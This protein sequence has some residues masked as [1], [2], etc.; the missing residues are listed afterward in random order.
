M[1]IQCVKEKLQIAISKAE[2]I[3]GKNLTL[4]ILSNILLEVK[5]DNLV[6]SSTNLDIGIEITVPGKVTETGKVVVPGNVLY[7]LVHTLTDPKIT[8][9]TKDQTLHISSDN[10]STTIKTVSDEDFPSIPNIPSRESFEMNTEGFLDGIRSVFYAAS[11]SNMKPELSSVYITSDEGNVI[12]VATDSFRLA[13]KKIK[14][15]K[16][17]NFQDILIPVKNVVEIIKTLDGVSGD[18]SIQISEG[19]L[20]LRTEEIYL[21]SRLVDGN[22][23]DY[24][25]IIPKEVSTNA[26]VLKQDFMNSLRTANIFSDKFNKIKFKVSP[27]E[28]QFVLQTKNTDLGENTT[29][30]DAAFSGEE[31]ELNFNHKYIVDSFQS[32]YSDSISL[33]FNGEGKPMIIKGVSD[34][35]FLY[36]AMPMSN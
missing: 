27:K 34:S 13:E 26:T 24:K 20:T 16:T 1:K 28:K 10:T 4:P 15:K 35:N 12:F 29:L 9:E 25:Q 30:I 6:I 7:S 19:Q 21:T 8:L 5:K 2:K 17:P 11:V 18:L 3:T 22:F 33:D 14:S 36:L 31:I 23:P 32:I